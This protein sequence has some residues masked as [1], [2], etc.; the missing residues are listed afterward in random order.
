MLYFSG[1]TK[2]NRSSRFAGFIIG[3]LTIFF[4]APADAAL[5]NPETDL[6]YQGAFRLPD[7]ESN[8]TSWSYGGHGMGY[9]PDGDPSG[10]S[11]G[12]PG[13]LFGISH[14]YQN[15]VSEFT[16]PAP[17]VSTAREVSEL[18]VATTLQTFADVTEGRQTQGL[19]GTTL[20]DIQYYPRMGGQTSAKLYW[21][22]YEYYLPDYAEVSHGWCEL[23]F[24]DL[25]SQGMWRLDDFAFAATSK[26]LFDIPAEWADVHAPG[27]YL[28]GGRHR[29]VN[30]GSWGPALYAFGPWNDGN[31]PANDSS[32]DA[33]E[34][35]MYEDIG[36]RQKDYSSN[37]DWE[38]GAWL[39]VGKKSAVIFT[40]MKAFRT[41]ASGLEY[42]GIY[43]QDGCGGKGY[44]AEPYYG[45]ILFYDPFLLAKAAQGA[46]AP[47]QIQ[48]Y[49]AL[50]VEDIVFK[51][52]C[53]RGILGGCAFDADRKILYVMEKFVEG[54]YARKPIVHVFQLTDQNQ[55]PDIDPPSVPS[56]LAAD[57]VAWDQVSLS[58][59]DSSDN[60]RLV[61]YVVFRNGEPFATTRETS[62]IDD[63]VNPD[64][65]YD[66]QVL[67][68]DA[69][70]NRS[71]LC[72]AL[73]VNTGAA[74]GADERAPIISG[75]AVDNLSDSTARI[76]WHTDELATTRVDYEIQYSQDPH[77]AQDPTPTRF[78]QVEL[79]GLADSSTY[80]F[81]AISEDAS[82]NVNTYPSKSFRTSPSG[83]SQN[84]EPFLNGIG[85]KQ[86]V[87]GQTL[88]FQISADDLD[89]EALSFSAP[90]VPPSAS[91]EPSSATFQW[92]PGY[93]D[94]G[95]YET[96]FTASD[97][98][99]SDSETVPIFVLND[100]DR[101]GECDEDDEDD[102]NDGYDDQIEELAKTDPLDDQSRPLIVCTDPLL[103]C[104]HCDPALSHCKEGINEALLFAEQNAEPGTVSL[105]YPGDGLYDEDSYSFEKNAIV[106]FEDGTV[107][108]Q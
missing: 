52:G 83:S 29:H 81:E 32:V 15:Y 33:V 96:T 8:D 63:K 73:E 45:C 34:L 78:H 101:D 43:Q 48:P 6:V 42:Y 13:S 99:Q 71:D 60:V 57:S 59:N 100:Q 22:I 102:D 30:S 5:I 70:N 2:P 94:A 38:D 69:R 40:G 90:D 11:D 39:A 106:F 97:G 65:E 87:E 16:I 24:S 88:E 95:A 62:Y 64:A 12:Y 86:V 51:Q 17:V 20:G 44:H 80:T 56:G 31:P 89:G 103:D 79:S 92:T 93:D 14:P 28:A 37:D 25:N 35:L 72:D 98:D 85:A 108:L 26:Y 21:V 55:S 49:A 75:I 58:W 1:K 68:W 47:N 84:A 54:Y 19:T 61:G 66:Y 104:G 9:R 23:D 10:P 41:R 18:P 74:S 4:F 105:I 36:L 82:A 76:T 7:E 46:I 67:A 50:N 77:T 3:L 91:F 27:K 107:A 53:R